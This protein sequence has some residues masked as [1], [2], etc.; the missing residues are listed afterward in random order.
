MTRTRSIEKNWH[1]PVLLKDE[2][3]SRY[4]S[5]DEEAA[6]DDARSWVVIIHEIRRMAT[7][8]ELKFTCTH[9]CQRSGLNF[10]VEPV[11]AQA[12]LYD[13]GPGSETDEAGPGSHSCPRC[14]D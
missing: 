5:R 8:M 12:F 4:Q 11:A 13:A 1:E 6:Q 3:C 14:K 7:T 2:A 10:E 9:W